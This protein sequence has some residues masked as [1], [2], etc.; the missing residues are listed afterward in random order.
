MDNDINIDVFLGE[1]NFDRIFNVFRSH[2]I[3]TIWQGSRNLNEIID[4]FMNGYKRDIVP[5]VRRFVEQYKVHKKNIISERTQLDKD[6]LGIV[7]DFMGMRRKSR[8]SRK[9]RKNS[10]RKSKK[11]NKSR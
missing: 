3:Y 10:R 1:G 8:K 2:S 11:Y 6:T 5:L 7:S 4:K 9:S